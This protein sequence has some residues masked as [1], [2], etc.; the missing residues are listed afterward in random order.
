MTVNRGPQLAETKK[1]KCNYSTCALNNF[2]KKRIYIKLDN[3]QYGIKLVHVAVVCM[4]HS[5]VTVPTLN[6]CC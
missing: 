3:A 6:Y 1:I 2:F 5:S 4:A